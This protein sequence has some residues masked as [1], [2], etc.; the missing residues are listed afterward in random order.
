MALAAAVKG[1]M[2]DLNK[3][4]QLAKEHLSREMIK[5]NARIEK[6]DNRHK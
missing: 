5:L 4:K 6:Y 1:K 2:I 3:L